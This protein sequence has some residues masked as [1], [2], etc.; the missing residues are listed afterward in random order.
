MTFL[1]VKSTPA[2]LCRNPRARETHS[3]SGARARHRQVFAW[4]A[5]TRRR[6]DTRVT[7]KG[8][9]FIAK[10]E[11]RPF[12]LLL[13]RLSFVVFNVFDA[14]IKGTSFLPETRGSAG[15]RVQVAI[16]TAGHSTTCDCEVRKL[17]HASRLTID[18][19]PPRVGEKAKAKAEANPKSDILEG[20][21]F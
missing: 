8:S 14:N 17:C 7:R 4:T 13:F 5:V 10:N 15:V 20:R 18:T 12:A 11:F 9:F 2:P 1:D 3:V 21:A 16:P 6:R 19:Q